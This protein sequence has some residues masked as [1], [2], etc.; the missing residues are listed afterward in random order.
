MS[1]LLLTSRL[2]LWYYRED[3]LS[4]RTDAFSKLPELYCALFAPIARTTTTTTLPGPPQSE[5]EDSLL[6]FL[7]DVD[8]GR[9]ETTPES[10]R[11]DILQ[12]LS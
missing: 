11:I 2:K 12:E 5:E 7:V 3:C 1:A 4:T 8:Y 6:N 9:E 10:Q